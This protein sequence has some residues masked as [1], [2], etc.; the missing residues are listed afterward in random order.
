MHCE[1]CGR[2]MTKKYDGWICL[3]CDPIEDRM[4]K[5]MKNEERLIKGDNHESNDR[6]IEEL[7]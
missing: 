1:E 7:R 6:Q 2:E 5:T 3:S 4:D